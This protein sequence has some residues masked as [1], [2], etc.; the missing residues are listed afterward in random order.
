MN[1]DFMPDIVCVNVVTLDK[2]RCQNGI[3]YSFYETCSDYTLGVTVKINCVLKFCLQA[4]T[5]SYKKV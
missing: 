3:Y 5:H 4:S 2:I 1:L